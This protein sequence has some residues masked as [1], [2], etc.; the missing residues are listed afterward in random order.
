M[1]C[2][3]SA[4]A[5]LMSATLPMLSTTSLIVKPASSTRRL[6]AP[7]L[8]TESSISALISLAAAAERCVGVRTSPATTAKPRPCSPERA[9]STAAFGAR[10]LV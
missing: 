3:C 2:V 10:M 6:P 5:A 8:P 9:A 7:T 4:V 1:P